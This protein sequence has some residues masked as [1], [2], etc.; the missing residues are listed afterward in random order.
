V[1]VDWTPFSSGRWTV[2]HG[3]QTWVPYEPFGYVTHHYGNWVRV[4]NRWY[5]GPP[6][7]RVMVR[8][9][10]PLFN[11]GFSWYPGRVGW[12]NS[13]INI[14][15]FPLAPYETYY[16]RR[17]WGP[18]S[19]VR[20]GRHNYYYNKHKY[21][22]YRHARVLKHGDLYRHNN[23]RRAGLHK[24]KNHNHYRG[25]AFAPDRKYHHRKR[26]NK[27][28]SSNDRLRYKP[29]RS[30]IARIRKHDSKRVGKL[31]YNS[32]PLKRSYKKRDNPISRNNRSIITGKNRIGLN[33]KRSADVRTDRNRKRFLD[34][35]FKKQSERKRSKSI[36]GNIRKKNKNRYTNADISTS[37][38]ITK[39][40]D[41]SKTSV[42]KK[43]R[44]VIKQKPGKSLQKKRS[45][46]KV[47][48][49]SDRTRDR[50]ISKVVKEKTRRTVKM[51]KTRPD[52]FS[53]GSSS[54]VIKQRNSR[55]LKNDRTI[56]QNQKR[57]IRT[58]QRKIITPST[59]KQS[60]KRSGSSISS[61][62]RSVKQ[63]TYGTGITR[64]NRSH[65]SKQG[66]NY[67]SRHGRGRQSRQSSSPYARE[68]RSGNSRSRRN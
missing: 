52:R 66:R 26:I 30:K 24:V 51:V 36:D 63:K 18:R 54:N 61:R 1:G 34:N 12:I 39:N 43:T 38:R 50:N 27:Y 57:T 33:K 60:R 10:L 6:V 64:Q 35:D 29:H 16:S 19:R 23:Y 4:R 48:T 53:K 31:R 20:H 62:G 28:K 40:R 46:K 49:R 41:G 7:S 44:N 25:A 65:Q 22:H 5:W 37:R 15:W 68:G 17:Y 56:K 47:T 58:S 13:S 42:E 11:I 21:R 9:G 14:G 32:R 2:W 55:S 67:E 8:A 59:S 45:T 3:E